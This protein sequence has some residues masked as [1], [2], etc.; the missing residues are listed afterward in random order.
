MPRYAKEWQGS[1]M[2]STAKEEPRSAMRSNGLAQ[3]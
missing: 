1:E 3:I 2:K